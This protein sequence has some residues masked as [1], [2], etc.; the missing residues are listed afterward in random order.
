MNSTHA[1]LVLAFF[2]ALVVHLAI[3]MIWSSENIGASIVNAVPVSYGQVILSE[4]GLQ[5]EIVQNLSTNSDQSTV[6]LPYLPLAKKS[7]EKPV[8]RPHSNSYLP[9]IQSEMDKTTQKQAYFELPDL[10]QAAEPENQ[11]WINLTGVNI[12]NDIQIVVE[13]F[14]SET[15][16]VDKVIFPESVNDYGIEKII[17]RDIRQTPFI[18]AVRQNMKVPSHKFIEFVFGP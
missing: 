8:N 18:P 14:I 4:Q 12:T 5:T 7:H 10:D 2:F 11:L 1:R 15:G 3:W 16:H 6:L 9:S 13:I 17:E